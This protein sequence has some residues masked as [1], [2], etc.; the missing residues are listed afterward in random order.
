M[1]KTS[2]ESVTKV[3][4]RQVDG[5]KSLL[6][7]NLSYENFLNVDG[8]ARNHFDNTYSEF[9][10]R[11]CEAESYITDYIKVCIKAIRFKR[12]HMVTFPYIKPIS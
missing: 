1:E 2:I 4:L 10:K 8:K 7:K 12:S 9:I 11:V 5:L 3:I 6:K